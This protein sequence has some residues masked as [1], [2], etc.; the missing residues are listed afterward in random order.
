MMTLR[1][2]RPESA[3]AYTPEMVEPGCWQVWAKG[4]FTT[5]PNLIVAALPPP[6]PEP[7][8]EPEPELEPEPEIEPDPEPEQVAAAA[9]ADSKVE[10]TAAAKPCPGYEAGVRGAC[11]HC[12]LPGDHAIHARRHEVHLPDRAAP[13]PQPEHEPDNSDE[14]AAATVLQRYTR[15]YIASQKAAPLIAEAAKKRSGEEQEASEEM[16]NR[17]PAAVRTGA[18]YSLL[19][20]F[21]LAF[22]L[23][24]PC[25]HLALKLF[26]SSVAAPAS[27]WVE[28]PVDQA[29]AEAR[30]NDQAALDAM[31]DDFPGNPLRG[32]E[33]DL[34]E[35][36]ADEV[37]PHAISHDNLRSQGT[38]LM[39][40]V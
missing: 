34:S 31:F 37:S 35:G 40:F 13:S 8:I 9:V 1:T 20:C 7:E 4:G 18:I 21:Y 39:I 38:V 27:G 17:I 11:H 14:A 32:A 22:T 36:D 23:F 10:F 24:L 6:E 19:P 30:S 33:T 2:K 16:S 25:F 28:P 3:D 5:D 12:G 15:R 26:F 29:A